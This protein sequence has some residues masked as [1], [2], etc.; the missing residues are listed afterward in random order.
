M[1]KKGTA[2]PIKFWL[3]L[4]DEIQEWANKEGIPFALAVNKLCD[5]GLY[6]S[7]YKFP[8]HKSKFTTN[9]E[10]EEENNGI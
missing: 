7:S 9:S 2:I 4:Q 5:L 3:G 8:F 6:H 1:D 10:E